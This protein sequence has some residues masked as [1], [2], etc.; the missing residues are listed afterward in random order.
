MPYPQI[1]FPA[2]WPSDSFLPPL[3]PDVE[4]VCGCHY[5]QLWISDTR[6]LHLGPSPPGWVYPSVGRV[7]PSRMV[8]FS[9]HSPARW[10]PTLVINIVTLFGNSWEKESHSVRTQRPSQVRPHKKEREMQN[11]PYDNV[12]LKI[13]HTMPVRIV[14]W[15]W[16][17]SCTPIRVHSFHNTNVLS[18]LSSCM[19]HVLLVLSAADGFPIR[20]CTI[21]C[22]LSRPPLA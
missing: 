6:L 20:I 17:V 1:V 22:E 7:W 9:L 18:K 13:S 16:M 19:C 8:C 10:R 21:C 3:S 4:P 12:W 2:P 11:I 5:G 15:M 14:V